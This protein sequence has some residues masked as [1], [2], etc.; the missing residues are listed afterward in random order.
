MVESMAGSTG[1]E[2]ATSGLT[3]LAFK[4]SH[5]SRSQLVAISKDVGD[6]LGD[7]CLSRIRA[8]DC[9]PPRAFSCQLFPERP[10]RGPR[11][12]DMT[13]QTQ[14]PAAPG[15]DATAGHSLTRWLLIQVAVSIPRCRPPAAE[16]LWTWAQRIAARRG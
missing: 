4:W 14:T 8:R 16:A 1:L 3:V 2:P 11:S 10:V 6:N 5:H 9:G 13:S 7:R 12:G 15:A